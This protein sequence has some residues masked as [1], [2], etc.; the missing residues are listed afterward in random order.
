MQEDLSKRKKL[1]DALRQLLAPLNHLLQHA[2]AHDGAQRRLRAL[3]QRLADVGDTKSGLVR[4]GDVVVDDR[5]Q[6]DGDVVL[7]QAGLLGHLDDL[8]LDVDL[9]ELLRQR[10][11]LDQARVD[12]AVEAAELGDE[13]DVA[14]ADGLVGVGAKDAAGD[15]AAG[16][17]DGSKGVDYEKSRSLAT[18]TWTFMIMIKGGM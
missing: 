18:R 14:L 16:A 5:G 2:R 9:D 4:G 10:V 17:D 6:V 15:G 7:G 1:T 3:D 12:G 13:A 8:D 11:D